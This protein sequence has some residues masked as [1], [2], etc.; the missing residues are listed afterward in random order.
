MYRM[1]PGQLCTVDGFGFPRPVIEDHVRAD[2]APSAAS[3]RFSGSKGRVSTC[4]DV[5]RGDWSAAES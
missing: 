5:I 4:C 3:V 1:S 2:G